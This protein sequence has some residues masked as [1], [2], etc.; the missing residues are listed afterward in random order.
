[1]NLFRYAPNKTISPKPPFARKPMLTV[2]PQRRNLYWPPN[3]FLN[4]YISVCQEI[5]A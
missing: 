2:S 3:Q 1:M 4:K 5:L